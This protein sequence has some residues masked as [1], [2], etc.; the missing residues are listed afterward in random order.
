MTTNDELEYERQRIR[1][2]RDSLNSVLKAFDLA[3]NV[4]NSSH[5]KMD[6]AQTAVIEATEQLTSTSTETTELVKSAIADLPA[7]TATS[8]L[9]QLDGAI[10]ASV[11]R[12]VITLAAAAKSTSDAAADLEQKSQKFILHN[13]AGGLV[14]G[15]VAGAIVAFTMMWLHSS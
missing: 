10:Q 1:D 7:S 2:L 5:E 4:I 14:A 9:Q 15:A 12:S 3:S 6:A 13:T 8:I 11:K